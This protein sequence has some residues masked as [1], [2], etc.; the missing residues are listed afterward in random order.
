MRFKDIILFT[1]TFLI[2]GC[3]G[4]YQSNKDE[5]VNE[6]E[7]VSCPSSGCMF[8]AV[9]DSGTILT[10]LDG[11]SWSSENSGTSNLLSDVIYINGTLISIGGV[12]VD[13]VSTVLKSTNGK[14][15]NPITTGTSK[16]LYDVA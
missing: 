2:M 9:G 10:S 11:N 15:W 4:S 6:L 7:T 3:D 12:F 16:I 8:V 5:M 13:N 1:L 14:T